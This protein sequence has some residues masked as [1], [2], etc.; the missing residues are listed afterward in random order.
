MDVIFSSLDQDDEIT[1][2]L[3]LTEVVSQLATC[4]PHVFHD[5]P[6]LPSLKLAARAPE[7]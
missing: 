4:F 5:L 6:D 3:E 2:S 7:N 1:M